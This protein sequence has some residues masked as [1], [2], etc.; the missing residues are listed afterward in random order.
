MCT[1]VLFCSMILDE[2]GGLYTFGSGA[3]G[4]LGHGDTM[5]QE[6]PVK[7]MEFGKKRQ[8][9]IMQHPAEDYCNY[10]SLDLVSCVICRKQQRAY[11]SDECRCRHEHGRLNNR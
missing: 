4:A 5:G 10:T 9:S 8:T 7:I 6:F 11:P 1:F 3:S 2:H